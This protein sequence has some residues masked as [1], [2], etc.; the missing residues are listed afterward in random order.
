MRRRTNI[1]ATIDWLTVVI[2]LFFVLFGW[3]NIYSAV[4][5]EEHHSIFSFT[6]RYGR[7]MI[8]ILVS[9]VLIFIIFIIKARYFSLFAYTTYIVMLLLLLIVLLFGSEVKGAKSWFMIGGF[10]FQPAEFTKIA[11]SMALAQMLSS[12]TF[13]SAK[14]KSF[15][16]PML[17]IA[18][19]MLLIILQNDTGSA[20]VFSVFILV[21][22]REGLPGGI[23]ILGFSFI[24]LFVMA[25][26]LQLQYSILVI[27]G[28]VLLIHWQ[29]QRRFSQVGK[30]LM[31]YAVTVAIIY[32]LQNKGFI[33]LN[34]AQILIIAFLIQTPYYLYWAFIKKVRH[35]Y[36]ILGVAILSMSFSFSIDYIFFKV[37]EQ[38]QRTR[39]SV[40]LG[41]EEDPHG[42][43][44]NVRQS[45]IAI[46]SGGFY[47]KG[48]MKGTQTKFDFVPEQSTDFIFCTVGEEWGFLGSSFLVGLY[49]FFIIRI[50]LI[51]ERQKQQFSRI[52][53][54]AVAS[55][56]FFHFAVNIGMTIGLA[57]VIGIP[58]PFFSYGGSSLWAFT[59]LLFIFLKLDSVRDQYYS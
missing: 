24:A 18:I 49:T 45:K 23:L 30:L 13:Q 19:P 10:G 43:G 46:G 42:A 55:L 5:N 7:Q 26:L 4:Y 37:L 48:F 59:L 12:P 54:Y 34:W 20:L 22:Y 47:G 44:Y 39:I 32:L 14:L 52:Y 15:I 8:L 53:G 2:Y 33:T 9:F 40:L 21:L 1:L 28:I 51:A 6:E 3:L 36:I 27:L 16:R 29:N 11:T 31:F 38:H 41:L 35:V 17:I 57:P 58:L 25:L 50:I 56:F